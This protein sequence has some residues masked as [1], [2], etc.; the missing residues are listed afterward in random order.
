MAEIH[1]YWNTLLLGF[2]ASA[3]PD[4]A[5]G[6]KAY[7]RNQFDFFGIKAPDRR[8]LMAEFKKLQALPSKDDLIAVI[9]SAWQHPCREMQYAGMELLFSYRKNFE[10][11]TIQLIEY[12]I[13][14]KSWWDTVDYIAPNI[15]A[16]YFK[17][18]PTTKA[19]VL[20]RWMASENIWLQ[21][22]CLI[23]QLKLKQQTDV[24]MLLNFSERLS[25]H[26]DFFIRKAIGWALRTYARVNPQ[27]VIDFV[28]S[29]PLSSLSKREALKHL[30]Y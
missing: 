17:L 4:V 19:A 23:F 28:E 10:V 26:P 16:N 22:S 21:R 13:T 25:A 14:A 9:Q 6:A 20:E 18:F 29:V 2:E 27:L 7:M 8:L 3:D 1:P 24:A 15:A 5:N 11:E 30:N 12:L